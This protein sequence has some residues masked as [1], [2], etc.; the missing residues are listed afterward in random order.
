MFIKRVRVVFVSML[1]S[2]VALAAQLTSEQQAAKE[3]GI[4]LY[5]QYKDAEPYLRIAA[6]AGDREA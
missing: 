2:G 3:K 5:N 6:E 1:L 4:T